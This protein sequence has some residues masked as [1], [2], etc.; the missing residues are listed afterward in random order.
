MLAVIFFSLELESF[1]SRDR[2]VKTF[3][4]SKVQ[5][6]KKETVKTYLLNFILRQ[7]QK[8]TLFSCQLVGLCVQ[9][10]NKQLPS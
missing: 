7:V 5:P 2:M 1:E 8:V 9:V 4:F 3:E 10:F 6:E